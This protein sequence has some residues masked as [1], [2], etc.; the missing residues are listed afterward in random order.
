MPKLALCGG[1][2]IRTKPFPAWPHFDEEEV[3]AVTRV[4][5][6]RKWWRYEGDEVREFEGEFARMQGAK[7]GTA[8][9]NGTTA[10]EVALQALGIGPGDEVIV[11]AYTFVAT[12]TCV[13]TV[14]AIPIFADIDLSTF[15]IDLDSVRHLTSPRTKA[16]IPVHFGGYPCN[17]DEIMAF[18]RES[19]L[20]V[21]EDA[22]HA[23]G[24]SWKGKGLGAIGDLGAFSFQ[25][26]K[27]MT[28]GEGGITITNSEELAARVSS[29]HSFGRLPRGAWYEHHMYSSNLRMTEFQAAVLRVQLSRLQAQNLT[30]AKNARVLTQKLRDI[31]GLIPVGAEKPAVEGRV[32]HLYI[33]RYLAE[34][35]EGIPKMLFVKA[36]NA[37]GI[38][39]SIGYPIPL[40]KQPLFTRKMARSKGCPFS[41]SAY[42]GEEVDYGSIHLPN[43]EKACEEAIW[44][45]QNVLLGDEKDIR[46]IVD[47]IIKVAENLD[48]L[49]Q[50]EA[51]GC[52]A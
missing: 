50:H 28:S 22:A 4:V 20:Y 7:Y 43:T 40:Y 42:C 5:Q 48:E 16:I 31:R 36:L 2:P 49:R 35:F 30:R 11:P 33:F 21:V 38:P 19:G 3:K 13:L 10:L 23:H 52:N 25:A 14:N 9:T 18:A 26:S 46:D 17:M 8:V 24:G 44:L 37:E 12:A 45:P 27:N 15:N 29:L 34:A 32:Y 41:C 39:A 47:A 6:S 1:N 51:G